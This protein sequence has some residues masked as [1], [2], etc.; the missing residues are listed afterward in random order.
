MSS[1][2]G[3]KFESVLMAVVK[4]EVDTLRMQERTDDGE[5]VVALPQP[6]AEAAAYQ[7]EVAEDMLSGGER[8][9]VADWMMYPE[10]IGSD[11]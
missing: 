11:W 2:T 7:S 8:A 4:E 6:R 5:E 9:V 1:T 10:A 3:R